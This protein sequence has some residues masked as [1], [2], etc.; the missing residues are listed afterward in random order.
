MSVD[1]KLE[2]R[3]EIAFSILNVV[4]SVQEDVKIARDMG[5][6]AYRISISWPRIL[7]GDVYVDLMLIC[8]FIINWYILM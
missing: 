8:V 2:I 3:D 6:D 5:L 7:P 4:V 1:L